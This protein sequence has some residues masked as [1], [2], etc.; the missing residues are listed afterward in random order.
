MIIFD[1]EWSWA[2][3]WSCIRSWE[4]SSAPKG[5]MYLY[6]WRLYTTFLNVSMIRYSMQVSKWVGYR[7]TSQDPCWLATAAEGDLRDPRQLRNRSPPVPKG[8]ESLQRS[9]GS[10]SQM[11]AEETKIHWHR[12]GRSVMQRFT[13]WM[14]VSCQQR[15]GPA[16]QW[17]RHSA[18]DST[19][20]LKHVW[21]LS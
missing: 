18:I 19:S 17:G 7:G 16:T 11:N 10:K 15:C 5:C 2:R 8:V 1:T 13:S 3:K 4:W 12:S 6:I 14:S 21:N 20:Q 9:K